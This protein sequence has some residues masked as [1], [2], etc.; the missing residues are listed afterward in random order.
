MSSAPNSY[1]LIHSS[2]GFTHQSL[3]S[4]KKSERIKTAFDHGNTVRSRITFLGRPLIILGPMGPMGPMVLISRGKKTYFTTRVVS[5]RY[6][7][8]AMGTFIYAR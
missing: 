2:V 7:V 5:F 8:T 1:S 4:K 6:I 3:T